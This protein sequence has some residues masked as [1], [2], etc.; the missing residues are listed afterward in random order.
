[1][2]CEFLKLA[3]VSALIC[4]VSCSTQSDSLSSGAGIEVPAD[5][6]AVSGPSR[7]TAVDAWVKDLNAPGLGALVDEAVAR[8]HDLKAAAARMRS[9]R[10]RAVMEGAQRWPQV[11]GT[12]NAGSSTSPMAMLRESRDTYDLG[13]NLRWEIDLWGRLRNLQRAAEDAY[14][15]TE[16]DYYAARLSLA[17]NTA[18]SWFN[19]VEAEQQL[20]L[21]NETLVSF[22]QN[23]GIVESSFDRGIGDDGRDAALD[24]RLARANVA[25]A[26]ARVADTG[27]NRDAAARSL[28]VLLGRYPAE[29]IPVSNL[30]PTLKKSVPTGLPSDLLLRRPDIL[31]QEQRL[32]AS[33]QRLV[34]SKKA[35]LPTL[36][37]TG[38]GGL[39]TESLRRLLSAE[40]LA[41]SIA[42][43]LAQPLFEGGRL[44]AGVDEAKANQEEA[45][46]N[47]TQTAL[48]A[49][50]EVETTLAAER[51]L[52]S[53]EAAL[54]VAAAESVEA[55]KL[56]EKQYERGLVEIV[57]VLE[58][59]RR[60]FDARSSLIAV[61]NQRLQ[62]RVDLYLALGGGF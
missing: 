15:A 27:G 35:F 25:T 33:G 7:S 60:S 54:K 45:L 8:N 30:L 18:K 40:S 58:A 50:R 61:S 32:A 14:A 4:F 36:S 43:G 19:A 6:A 51:Y 49:F 20:R 57:T 53:Q 29:S 17:A 56:A 24:V 31:S 42:A 38:S 10:A 41:T 55:E 22:E 62:N 34:A 5:Y 11:A 48:V 2:L 39:Q 13:L 16:S 59:Q 12:S 1:M 44:K 26:R 9:A 3:G 46:E 37:L 23:L 47:F 52:E 28:E 21:A